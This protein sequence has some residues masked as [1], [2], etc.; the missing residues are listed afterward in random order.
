MSHQPEQFHA[1]ITRNSKT[2]R[3][4]A[5]CFAGLV[6]RVVGRRYERG[7]IVASNPYRSKGADQDSYVCHFRIIE[8]ANETELRRVQAG[9]RRRV[10]KAGKRMAEVGRWG[11]GCWY[12][13]IED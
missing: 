3:G 2:I 8:L 1:S 13:V 5:D 10:R 4:V 9:Y 7:D 11:T 6:F 12:R